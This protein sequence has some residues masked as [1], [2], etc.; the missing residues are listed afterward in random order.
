MTQTH[1]HGPGC[2]ICDHFARV[3]ADATV[4]SDA[5]WIASGMS[6]VPGWVMVATRQH[7]EGSWGLSDREAATAGPVLRALSRALKEAVGAER[8]HLMAQGEHA[9]HFHY[10]MTARGPG[11][12][13]IFDT[14]ELARRSP[15][16]ADRAQASAAAERI[17]TLLAK[18]PT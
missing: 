12:T 5:D 13:P 16:L 15:A 14:A 8:V 11:D 18:A 4:W 10:L 9:V 6:D 2:L 17:R 7:S 3:S 1:E